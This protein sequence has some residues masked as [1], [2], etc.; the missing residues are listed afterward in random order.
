MLKIQPKQLRICRVVSDR[1]QGFILGGVRH[2]YIHMQGERKKKRKG[3]A[4]R[5]YVV[6]NPASHKIAVE[7]SN[8]FKNNVFL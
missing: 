3:E 5:T 6:D 1:K 4:E 8:L 2:P 7:S